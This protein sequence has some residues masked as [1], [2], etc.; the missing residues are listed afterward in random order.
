MGLFNLI[1]LSLLPTVASLSQKN[2]NFRRSEESRRNIL[3][4][5]L[6]TIAFASVVYAKPALALK[7]RNE[8]LCGTGFFT[9]IGKL[10]A[11]V[12]PGCLVSKQDI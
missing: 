8:A 6:Q 9:N 10:L 12:T 1:L 7:E 2:T 5:S 11:N 3:I 4:Q